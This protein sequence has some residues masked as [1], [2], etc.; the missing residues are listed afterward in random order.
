MAQFAEAGLITDLSDVWPIDGLN[1]SFKEASTAPDGK[2]YF[3]PV[4]LYPWA[5]YEVGLREER[6]DR[7]NPPSDDLFALMDNMQGKKITPFAFGD[8]DGWPAMGT[9]DIL[10]M[11]LNGFD[12]HM[13]LMAGEEK[14]D[15]DR[16]E[17]SL[18]PGRT[19]FPTTRPTRSVAPGRRPRP[20]WARAS[21]GCTSS[22]R[23]WLDTISDVAD[24]LDFFTFP[25]LDS[26]IGADAGRP[27]RRLLR[28][29]GSKNQEAAKEM[30][31]SL[32]SAEAADAANE[33]ADAPFITA[34]C[35]ASAK[36]TPTCRRS[37]PRSWARRPTSQFMDRDTNADFANT[38]I[39]PSIQ[40]FLKDPDD[41]DHDSGQHRERPPRSWL[42]HVDIDEAPQRVKAEA[43]VP[44]AREGEA[45]RAR[46]GHGHHDGGGTTSPR[47]PPGVGAGAAVGGALVRSLERLRRPRH[48]QWVGVPELPAT[49]SSPSLPRRSGRRSSTT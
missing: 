38:V 5:V 33:G 27:D 14:W 49:T 39:I 43:P 42:S 19:C 2:Q 13:S 30:V 34:D 20:P 44:G 45:A 8:K 24:D 37:R 29:G 1:D 16:V 4:K 23:S 15:G 35:N 17:P 7:R 9:F 41:I 10:N 31:E 47:R 22:A 28:R 32:G 25:A 11:R 46:P 48:H 36:P 26:T 40:A 21:P 3:V 18:R 6:L 12:F